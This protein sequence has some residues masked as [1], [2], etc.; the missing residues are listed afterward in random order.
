MIYVGAGPLRTLAELQRK[1]ETRTAGG[2]TEVSWVKE[3]DI[4]CR[5]KGLSGR[6]KLEAMS[7]EPQI[8]HEITVRR[9][10]GLDARKRLVIRHASGSLG[11]LDRVLL[12]DSLKF[13]YNC[14]ETSGTR[15]DSGPNG[16]DVPQIGTVTS[17]TGKRGLGVNGIGNTSNYLEAVHNDLFRIGDNPFTLS[18]WAYIPTGTL[19]TN[20]P[21]ISHYQNSGNQRG[22]VAYMQNANDRHSFAV[23]SDGAS[24]TQVSWGSAPVFDTW[25]HVVCTH[26]P[27]LDIITISVDGGTPVSAAF[28]GGVFAATAPLGITSWRASSHIVG[29]GD[30]DEIGAWD[31]LL[32]DQ[33]LEYLGQA[34]SFDSFI[35]S[36]DRTFMIAGIPEN[37]DERGR[38][39]KFMAVEGVAT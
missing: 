24:D 22:W 29:I 28:S 15:V 31:R 14:D 13:Y 26:D 38:Y 34:P 9:E 3:R 12:L 18:Y 37:V 36:I 11:A 6:M 17:V 8:T 25:Q 10:G 20:H 23:S 19:T 35:E 1:V 39:V 16:L 27:D 21:A 5:V 4:W 30:V 32:N 2:G 33:E 7:R